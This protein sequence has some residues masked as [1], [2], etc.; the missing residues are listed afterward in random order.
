MSLINS[1][2]KV[3]GSEL[4]V[5]ACGYLLIP[6]Y[7]QIMPKDQ[8]GEFTYL[9][10][11]IAGLA[12][13][14]TC[15]I[16]ISQN[17]LGSISKSFEQKKIIFF[18]TLVFVFLISSI[19]TF[20]SLA[21]GFTVYLFEF[22]GFSLDHIY[23]KSLITTFLL[24]ITSV[25]LVVLTQNIII[26]NIKN[27]ILFTF[28]KFISLNLTSVIFLHYQISGLDETIDRL[29]GILFGELFLCIIFLS[30]FLRSFIKSKIDLNYLKNGLK[31]SL[32]LMMAAIFSIIYTTSDRYFIVQYFSI[33]EL[34]DYNIAHLF[35]SPILILT[36][37]FVNVWSPIFFAQSTAKFN[38]KIMLKNMIFLFAIVFSIASLI[39][40]S[41]KGGLYLGVIQKSY[42]NVPTYVF[43]LSFSY[44]FL[45]YKS[46][47]EIYF[48]KYF[49]SK[50]I[51][52]CTTA[53]AIF[54]VFFGYK[55]IPNM[56]VYG[57]IAANLIS[58]VLIILLYFS[59]T[60]IVSSEN[61]LKRT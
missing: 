16:Y 49:G 18:T 13:I 30:F 1:V 36:A 2:Y 8:V 52:I 48:I 37:S 23:L 46:V 6:F 20:T 7:L 50:I 24:I 3:S 41:I 4:I 14:L 38:V 17:H 21:L 11:F 22:M 40:L 58:N 54:L 55:L 5:R 26:K 59:F 9:I 47:F 10:G 56:G 15:S 43:F 53:Q 19:I 27:L 29:L 39:G 57:A 42:L 33:I 25:N 45:S 60:Q 28:I 44:C 12:N 61:N 35:L 32:P 31:S 34:T 51:L